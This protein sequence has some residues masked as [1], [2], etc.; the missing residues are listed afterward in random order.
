MSHTWEH[1]ETTFTGNS[2]LSG[3]IRIRRGDDEIEI[4]GRDILE[5]VAYHVQRCRISEIEQQETAKLLGISDR[6]FP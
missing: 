5:F 4:P 1:G 2:D 3:D 6:Y